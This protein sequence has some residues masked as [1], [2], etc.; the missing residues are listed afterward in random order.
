MLLFVTITPIFDIYSLI[1]FWFI[2]IC[3]HRSGVNFDARRHGSTC[4]SMKRHAFNIHN[5]LTCLL[6][7]YIW[8]CVCAYCYHKRIGQSINQMNYARFKRASH[9]FNSFQFI[10]LFLW[11]S[12]LSIYCKRSTCS[13]LFEHPFEA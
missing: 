7:W 6:V 10:W 5:S 1:S 9:N 12:Y 2:R 3:S 8:Y 13:L 11:T 4:L